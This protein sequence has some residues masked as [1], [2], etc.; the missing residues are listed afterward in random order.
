M[1]KPGSVVLIK[2]HPSSGQELK[3]FRPAII[4]QYYPIRDF[5]TFI[6]LTSQV[7]TKSPLELPIVPNASNS[8]DQISL[9]LCWYVQTV[10]SKRIQKSLGNLDA[11][12][13]RQILSL[14][15]KYLNL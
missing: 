12:V 7:K 3:K 1:Y 8:L 6:P 5:V 15:K 2:M 10:G 13:F 4:L 11:K 14:S 9:A